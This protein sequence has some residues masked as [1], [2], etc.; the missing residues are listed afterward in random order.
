LQLAGVTRGGP[1]TEVLAVSASDYEYAAL[2]TDGVHSFRRAAQAAAG[3][4]VEAVPTD[5]AL[6]ALVSF[7]SGNGSFVGRRMK[8]FRK[9]CQAWGWQ[10][11]D[12]VAVG[13]L[14]LGG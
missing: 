2:L 13:A 1:L 12:D 6:R 9:D 3:G 4:C 11:D 8:R 14:H 5:E 10:H 7:K